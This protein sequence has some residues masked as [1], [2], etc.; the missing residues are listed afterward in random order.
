MLRPLGKNNPIEVRGIPAASATRRA[1]DLTK[2]IRPVPGYETVSL[3][4]ELS[5]TLAYYKSAIGQFAGRDS[6]FEGFVEPRS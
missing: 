3:D 5:R 6:G 4:E 1:P 2:V